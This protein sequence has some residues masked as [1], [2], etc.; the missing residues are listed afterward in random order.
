MLIYKSHVANLTLS[1]PQILLIDADGIDPEPAMGMRKT[2][3]A[4]RDVEV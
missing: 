2:K 1:L 4:K 3:I